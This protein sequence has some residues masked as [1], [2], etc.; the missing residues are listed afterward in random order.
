[1]IDLNNPSPCEGEG[2]GEVEKTI[3][4]I[5]KL[6]ALSRSPNQ[7][8]AESA[9]AKAYELM[10]RYHLELADIKEKPEF[11]RHRGTYGKREPL[12]FRFTFPI[13]RDFFHVQVVSH[14]S[15][16]WGDFAFTICGTRQN[17][18]I[19]E[20]VAA[21]LFVTYQN[22]WKTNI[23]ELTTPRMGLKRKRQIKENYY[24]GVYRGLNWR[25]KEA[26]RQFAGG[27]LVG[28]I[29]LSDALT[30]YVAQQFPNMM[31]NKIKYRHND[32]GA[33]HA[34][35]LDG[36]QIDIRKPIAS[37]RRDQTKLLSGGQ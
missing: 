36:K 21:F 17:I 6:L 7:H 14:G 4:K 13:L 8:E 24:L 26:Q 15:P 30:D 25:L 35:F 16:R 33:L 23:R 34:G 12:E 28:L 10:E 9:L 19:A 27:N 20:Y 5:R 1:M 11:E 31:E 18:L 29:K 3:D 2:L 22:L 37:S 32:N